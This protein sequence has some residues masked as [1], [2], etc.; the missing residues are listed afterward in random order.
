[1][2]VIEIKY[3]LFIKIV[4]ISSFRKIKFILKKKIT[5]KRKFLI[6]FRVILVFYYFKEIKLKKSFNI[7][8]RKLQKIL[9][10]KNYVS[11]S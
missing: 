6:S 7:I 8:L 2:F 11:F 4:L 3:N 1:M 5:E 9:K 10:I